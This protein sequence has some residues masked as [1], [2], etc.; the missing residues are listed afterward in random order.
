MPT[1]PRPLVTP[2]DAAVW[3]A[4]HYGIE[5]QVKELPSYADRNF[6]MDSAAGRYVLKISHND[7]FRQD[8]ELE[9]A[10]MA[11]LAESDLGVAVARVLRDRGGQR[12]GELDTAESSYLARMLTFLPGRPL[13]ESPPKELRQFENLGALVGRLD[14]ALEDFVHPRDGRRHSWDLR[15]GAA[16]RDLVRWVEDGVD[17]R[18]AE[19]AFTRFTDLAWPRLPSLRQSV[20]HN[21]VNDYNLLLDDPGEL[22]GLI[23]FGDVVRT[24]TVCDL[25]IACAYAALRQ[26]EPWPVVEAVARGYHAVYRLREEEIELLHPLLLGR[27]AISVVMSFKEQRQEPD[28]KYLTV[29]QRPALTALA[30]LI[31]L[32]PADAASRFR[33]AC[34]G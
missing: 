26:Q 21:D 1:I 10:I 13:A 8:L 18:L 2:E 3:A 9:N 31:E 14:A 24:A 6:M 27:L 25:A 30:K 32:P 23:D 22:C 15:H 20:I 19:R 11:R 16:H 28:N 5:G 7:T 17:R 29:T 33:Q 34:G 12:I 4:E